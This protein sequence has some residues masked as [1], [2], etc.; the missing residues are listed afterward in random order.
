LGRQFSRFNEAGF[1]T[2]LIGCLA[3]E[4]RSTLALIF[5][6]T[7]LVLLSVCLFCPAPVMA[8]GYDEI[9]M[10]VQAEEQ[11]FGRADYSKSLEQ[12]LEILETKVLG[13]MQTGS[14]SA[15]LRRIC[16]TLGISVPEG[17]LA[18]AP[19]SV[20]VA[21]AGKAGLPDGKLKAANVSPT[22]SSLKTQNLKKQ[23]LQHKTKMVA[24]LNQADGKPGCHAA[25]A[26][27]KTAPVQPVSAAVNENEPAVPVKAAGIEN[28]TSANNSVVFVG[29]AAIIF[30]IAGACV[31][32]VG[33][34]Q[35]GKSESTVLI[36]RRRQDTSFDDLLGRIIWQNEAAPQAAADAAA[37]FAEPVSSAE[38][39]PA[40]EPVLPAAPELLVE[41][42]PSAEPAQLLPDL[43][44][45][46][47]IQ[48]DVESA[49]SGMLDAGDQVDTQATWFDI[50][51]IK[52]ATELPVEKAIS[53]PG[54]PIA[55][56]FALAGL[57]EALTDSTHVED[58]SVEWQS[59]VTGNNTFTS[60]S[61]VPL[62]AEDLAGTSVER[63]EPALS[64][65]KSGLSNVVVNTTQVGII[66]NEF[67]SLA[68]SLGML[69]DYF[70]EE[71]EPAADL[72]GDRNPEIPSGYEPVASADA[73]PI[74]LDDETPVPSAYSL[75]VVE[76]FSE[77]FA[78]LDSDTT[79]DESDKVDSWPDFEEEISPLISSVSSWRLSRQS[80]QHSAESDY[81]PVDSPLAT[82]VIV[83][84]VLNM[85]LS[86]D[87]RSDHDDFAAQASFDP[88]VVELDV[89]GYRALAQL[90]IETAQQAA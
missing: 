87:A 4:G 62:I 11:V 90:L 78:P 18:A 84:P 50:E 30:T 86:A 26:E 48:R 40:A 14:D 5:K 58:F 67:S 6:I 29:W 13:S 75:N 1:K 65:L 63:S 34:L 72:P 55:K 47:Q 17:S 9:V 60:G 69:R 85:D 27:S 64:E 36:P 52:T 70:P 23:R 54:S 76:L 37:S 59:S 21:S 7:I 56:L 73:E 2:A 16:R 38:P 25:P 15:R 45:D 77:D 49:L 46:T 12:R 44:I 68:D 20:T 53:N 79:F 61:F 81:S 83:A 74:A 22:A 57:D 42:L 19:Y 71:A 33:L 51:P 35:H 43:Q 3:C 32:A 39:V 8:F 82:S 89:T 10:I 66:D 41:S 24:V 80:R 88:V 31:V 28:N